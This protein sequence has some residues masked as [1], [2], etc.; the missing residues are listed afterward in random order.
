MA[1]RSLVILKPD[2]VHRGLIGQVTARIEQR[3]FKIVA[4][5]SRNRCLYDYGASSISH[6]RR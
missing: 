2:T 1:E 3:G 4:I 5:L 6:R